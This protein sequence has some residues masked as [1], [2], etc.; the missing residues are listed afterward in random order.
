MV[1]SI[2]L[3]AVPCFML[4]GCFTHIKQ[5]ESDYPDKQVSDKKIY[6]PLLYP[7]SSIS[8]ELLSEAYDAK[9]CS[10]PE[11]SVF[12]MSNGFRY[13][14]FCGSLYPALEHKSGKRFNELSDIERFEL[15][16]TYYAIRPI[17]EIDGACLR[18]DV[19]VVMAGKQTIECNDRFK[20]E[21][22]KM[23][24]AFY[25]EIEHKNATVNISHRCWLLTNDIS[26]AFNTPVPEGKSD[27]VSDQRIDAF[28][29]W[30]ATVLVGWAY[31]GWRVGLAELAGYK[32]PMEAE[33]CFTKN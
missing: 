24:G 28:S 21:I 4:S 30:S 31:V 33:K 32:Y 19:C 18:H 22:N 8:R 16:I 17:D 3:I 11:V 12:T 2:V 5:I 27:N 6:P 25:D 10:N 9:E 15:A 26:V 14:C 29:R 23:N 13:G 20:D 7:D 1:K